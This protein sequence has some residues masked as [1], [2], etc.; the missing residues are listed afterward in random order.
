[1]NVERP[2]KPRQFIVTSILDYDRV[3]CHYYNPIYFETIGKLREISKSSGFELVPLQ[4]LLDSNSPRNLTGGATPLGAVYLLDGVPFIRIQNVKETGIELSGVAF[5]EKRVHEG[6]LKRSQ[7]QPKDILLTITGTYGISVVVPKDFGEANINQHIVKIVVDKS[8]MIPEYLSMY[9][10]SEYGRNQMNRAVTGGTRLALD[11]GSIRRLQIL[12]PETPIQEKIV[13]EIQ[14]IYQEA[15]AIQKEISKL[16]AFYDSVV[17]SKLGIKLPDEPK[18]KTFLSSIQEQD[19][20]EV[21]WHYPYYDKV[22]KIL[23]SFKSKKLG[24]Y[25]H[26]LKY[27]ASIDANYVS[28]IPFLRIENLRRNY[29]DL[30]DLQYIPSG[31]YKNEVA[32]LYLQEGDILIERSG[33][34]VGLCSYVPE[35]MESYVH[36]SYMIRLRLD[37]EEILPRYLSVYL[38]SILGRIQFDRLKTGSLQFNINIQQIRDVVIIEPDIDVQEDVAST[39]YQLIN[40]VAMLRRQYQE[41]LTEAKTRFIELHRSQRNKFC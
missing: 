17:L 4:R 16:E 37:D 7:L 5:I 32:R 39:V 24:K 20:L 14:K 36:G 9:L 40:Q 23:S 21:K 27:G 2:N 22:I 19:R 41:K 35:G 10:N 26:K 34:Y 33:T 11:Y 13:K 8:R 30:S 29:I 3:D 6:E 38:N 31:V 28:D 25:R 15:N 18:L 12:R 1:M